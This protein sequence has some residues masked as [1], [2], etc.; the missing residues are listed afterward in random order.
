M[1]K[2]KNVTKKYGN[3]IAV[4]NLNLEIKKGE[5][6]GFVGPNGAGKTTTMR[7]IAT[8]LEPTSGEIWINDRNL[9]ED[10]NGVRSQ[11][12]YMPDFFGV[13]NDLK[14]EEYMTF[15]GDLNKVPEKELNKRIDQ[16]LELVGLTEKKNAYVDALSRGMKQRLCLA[17]ALIHNPELLILDEP[18]SGMDPRARVHMKNILKELKSMGKT[19]IISS[20]ILPEIAEICTSIGIIERGKIITRDSV[21]GIINSA[22]ENNIVRIKTLNKVE[23]LETILRENPYI[24]EVQNRDYE[25]AV[26]FNGSDEKKSELLKDIVKANISIVN[27]GNTDQNLEDIFMKVTKGEEYD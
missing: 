23:E 8:L 4:D 7:M 6:F 1:L 25:F 26:E 20:H 12:G 19:V 15:Y 3:F 5:I 11:I 24:T 22:G 18:A 16:L 2:L 10:L 9:N 21:D 13:Y 17:R 27:F 14:V